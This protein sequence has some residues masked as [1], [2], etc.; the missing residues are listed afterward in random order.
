MKKLDLVMKNLKVMLLLI[1]MVAVSTTFFSCKDDDD[2]NPLVLTGITAQDIALDEVT[3]AT[4]VPVDANIVIAFDRNVNNAGNITLSNG[5]GD[6]EI[7]VDVVGNT[8][9]VQP[10][11]SLDPGT[12]YTLSVQNVVA[13][14]GGTYSGI[15]ISFT[16]Y[17][18]GFVTPPKD[19]SMMAYWMF[20]GNTDDRLGNYTTSDEV[21][22]TYTT[23]RAGFE[24][25]AVLFNGNTSIIEIENGA[26]LLTQD[27]TLSFWMR[28][29][30]VNH[31]TAD[32]FRA[33]HFVMGVGAFHG[34][35][36]EVG[37]DGNS[38]KKATR[39]STTDGTSIPNDFFINADGQSADQGG[40][41]GIEYER[42][43]TPLGGLSAI[44]PQQWA[45]VIFT[46]NS[47]ANTR[48][49]Y[50]NGDRIQTDNFG[51]VASLANINGMTFDLAGTAETIGDKLAFGFAFDRSTTLWQNEPWGSY[52]SPTSNHF[53][54]ALDDVRFFNTFYT[55]SDAQTLFDA[56]N[57]N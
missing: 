25:S 29:D 24:N 17:G 9:V 52:N 37:G 50:V 47:A 10:L 21:A 3:A 57:V 36:I 2:V 27:W 41:E 16:T 30:T 38:I 6:V 40:W 33:G 56:E 13:Q 43:L 46:Y 45:H 53:K 39:Y 14:D 12:T 18:K 15:Q 23:D 11:E 54:G 22:I 8:V 5:A 31:L 4:E 28:L 1:M 48:T 20:D 44:F 32:G 51:N 42:D 35:W 34:F 55:D 49:L 26:D 7:D 19:D